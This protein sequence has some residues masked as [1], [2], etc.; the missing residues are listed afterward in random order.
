MALSKLRQDE[1]G[2]RTTTSKVI[3]LISD[4]EDFGDE[5][6]DALRAIEEEGIRLFTLG[7]GTEKGSPIPG[8]GGY[9]TDRDGRTVTT[10]LNS[11]ALR[12]MA[13]LTGGEYF[14]ISASRNDVARLISRISNIQGDARDAR[15]VDVSAN[16][17]LYFLV[18]AMVLLAADIITNVKTLHI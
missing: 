3:I 13:T 10:R 4:G 17:Y 2:A 7:V 5:T 6:E 16:R 9:K 14:E 8:S 11:S 15:Q 12:N 1:K 18:A